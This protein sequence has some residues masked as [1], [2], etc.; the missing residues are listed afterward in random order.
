MTV[1]RSDFNPTNHEDS[2]IGNQTQFIL[3]LL[4][5]SLERQTEASE[6]T[7]VKVE[8]LGDRIEGSITRLTSEVSK[9]MRE[10][11]RAQTKLIFW[12][13]CLS[14]IF[15]GSIA[16]VQFFAQLDK[17]SITISTDRKAP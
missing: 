6:K 7:S 2:T 16:G 14:I 12:L 5:R 8:Q 15:L 13:L 1:R 17:D 10:G 9:E 3:E 11:L 4:E